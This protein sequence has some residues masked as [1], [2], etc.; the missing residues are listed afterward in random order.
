[1]TDNN[2]FKLGLALSGGGFR[3]ALFHVGVLAR[4]AELDLLRK[5]D[6]ISSVSGGSIIAAYY[7]LKVKALLEQ[8]PA[9]DQEPPGREAYIRLV[10]EIETDFLAGV[11]KNMLMRTFLDPVKNARM[12][13]AEF[14]NTERLAELLTTYFYQPIIQ[15]RGAGRMDNR[16]PLKNIPIHPI[17]ANLAAGTRVPFLIINATTLN[18]GH[19]WQFNS[20]SVGEQQTE[21]KADHDIGFLR[22][23][24]INNDRLTMEQRKILYNITL[25]QAVAASSCVPGI[26]EPLQIRNL[27]KAAGEPLTVRLVDG[28]LVDNQGLV[29]L[30]AENCS[31]I[32]CSDASDILKPEHHSSAQFL[33][34]ALR[35]N[36]ILMDRIR[37]KSLNEL[38]AYGPGR[39]ALFDMGDHETRDNIFPA[40]SAKMVRALTR[41]RTAMDSFTDREADSLMYYGYQLS[42]KVMENN[43][44]ELVN[45]SLSAFEKWRFLEIRDRFLNN[46]AHRDDLL[47]HLEVGSRQMF[48]VFLL[49]KTM[50]YIISLPFPVIFILLILYLISRLSPMVFWSLLILFFLVLVYTQNQKILKLM[51]N[52]AVLRR[53]KHRILKTMVS[54][55]LPEPF[56]YIMALASWIQLHVF[57]PLFLKYGRIREIPGDSGSRRQ[58]RWI[59]WRG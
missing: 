13:A 39:F 14:S 18:T 59:F 57:D 47:H 51:D 26:F 38:F 32:I 37:S 29:S 19:L 43:G 17:A 56:S 46:D 25:G 4:L 52:V 3:S 36:D 45:E 1:M 8:S 28:G 53:I 21:H 30:F 31:H 16:I 34:V 40:D 27:Y 9:P 41:V 24:Q 5:V 7:Y 55:R 22:K 42:R 50:P 10:A 20:V 33:N 6:V 54:L 15:P 49:K 48:K 35:A 11:Q 12:L 23:F 58:K 2:D 44:F